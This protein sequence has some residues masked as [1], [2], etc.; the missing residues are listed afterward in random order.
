MVRFL[1]LSPQVGCNT[2]M[3]FWRNGCYKRW[4]AFR[5]RKG[6]DSPSSRRKMPFVLV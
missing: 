3:D 4:F 6:A 2:C 1:K 5:N